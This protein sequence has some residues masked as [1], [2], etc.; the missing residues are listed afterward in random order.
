LTSDHTTPLI[1]VGIDGITLDLIMPWVEAGKLPHFAQFMRKGTYGRLRSV[2]Q[3]LSAPAWASF[4]TGV[5]PGKHSVYHFF[6]LKGRGVPFPVNASSIRFKPFWKVASEHGKRVALINL[7]GTY[8][9][10][11]INGILISGMMAPSQG[12][13]CFPDSLLDEIRGAVG[14]Y[15]LDVDVAP[16]LVGSMSPDDLA[17]TLFEMTRLRIKAAHY[18]LARER[19]DLF[20]LVFVSTDRIQHFF[21]KYMD[22]I[23]SDVSAEERERYGSVILDL[24]MLLDEFLGELCEI[25]GDKANIIIV[26]DH[27]FGPIYL[28]IN[29]NRWLVHQGFLKPKT[30]V[31][32]ERSLYQRVHDLI[33]PRGI[34]WLRDR[35]LPVVPRLSMGDQLGI[36]WRGTK[37]YNLGDFGNIYVNLKGRDLRG[38]VEAGQEYE[39]V[40]DSISRQLLSWKNPE[41]GKPLVRAVHRG[42]EI[43][44]GPYTDTAPDL[45][46]E[47]ENYAYTSYHLQKVE[48][49]LFAKPHES[50]YSGS[51]EYCANHRLDG[52]AFLRG[53]AFRAGVM[54]NNARIIDIAP[55]CLHL[56]GLPISDELD[57]RVLLNAMHKDLRNVS[58]AAGGF[59]DNG[60]GQVGTDEMMVPDHNYSYDELIE[61]EER[62]RNLGYL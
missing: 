60:L 61:I 25:V 57:G 10:S 21:W 32:V 3:P 1:I 48:D 38:I 58:S 53:P 16:G 20:L 29:L 43:Y 23:R 41:T 42:D 17:G 18:L 9:I 14:G 12:R 30:R 44:V 50:M 33:P 39:R 13:I 26:S 8:P 4:Q 37:A 15:V 35:F 6:E 36:D 49:P 22:P 46:I 56:M 5:N 55:T 7:L 45:V 54:L 51:M 19:W 62:L 28:D 11:P 31:A 40:C 47:W 2:F 34:K 27:G 52:V 24:Y 59:K